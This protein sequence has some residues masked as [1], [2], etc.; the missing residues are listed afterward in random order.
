MFGLGKRRPK[1]PPPPCPDC[2]KPTSNA[3]RFCKHCGWDADLQETE[4]A[5]LDGIVLPQ[6]MDD[7]G[8]ADLLASEALRA[9]RA[10]GRGVVFTLA[11]ILLLLALVWS[12]VLW[13]RPF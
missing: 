1:P 3:G 4:D 11:A 6:A 2:G 8:Y 13:G 5:H 9:P 10:R 7:E 12:T